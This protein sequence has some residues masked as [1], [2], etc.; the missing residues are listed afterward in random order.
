MQDISLEQA[1]SV[2][3]EH[4]KKIE[5]VEEVP[6]LEALGRVLAEDAVATF[7]NP[8]FDRSPLDGYTFAAAGTKGGDEGGTGCLH[9]HRRGVCRGF[10]RGRSASG[11]GCAPDD[12]RGHPQ[13]L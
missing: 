7:D 2:L 8:P 11:L 13:G 10:L 5:A 6:L 9:G 3:L 12:G 1:I 4:T